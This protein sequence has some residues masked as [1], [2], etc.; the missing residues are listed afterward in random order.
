MFFGGSMNQ[1]DGTAWCR[2]D[3]DEA[4][5][6]FG[7]VNGPDRRTARAAAGDRART[8]RRPL[9]KSTKPKPTRKESPARPTAP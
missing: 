3:G 2:H 7:M 8:P 6:M 4:A 5:F 1:R 9:R